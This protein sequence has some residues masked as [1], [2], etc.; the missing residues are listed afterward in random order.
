[1]KFFIVRRYIRGIAKAGACGLSAL[2][3]L[4]AKCG[5]RFLKSSDLSQPPE[6]LSIDDVPTT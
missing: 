4:A 6:E 3:T 5:G 2:P 1:M